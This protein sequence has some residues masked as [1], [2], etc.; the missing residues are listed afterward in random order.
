MQCVSRN[1]NENF[2]GDGWGW[3]HFVSPVIAGDALH[4]VADLC[5]ILEKGFR[6]GFLQSNRKSRP[7]N[8]ILLP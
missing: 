4:A 2:F 8:F 5:I 1:G 7:E 3:M 6:I